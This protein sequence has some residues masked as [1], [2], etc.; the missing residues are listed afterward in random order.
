[1]IDLFKKYKN[2]F[3]CGAVDQDV[4]KYNK[5]IKMLYPIFGIL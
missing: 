3:E 5:T 2:H 4:F 1:M